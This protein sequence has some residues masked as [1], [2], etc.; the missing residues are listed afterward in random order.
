MAMAWA[1]T[2]AHWGAC[3]G[4]DE[5][6]TSS[7]DKFEYVGSRPIVYVSHDHH[8]NYDTHS[9][10]DARVGDE[11]G[12][13][14]KERVGI[15]KNIGNAAHPFRLMTSPA[16][17]PDCTRSLYSLNPGMECYLNH[18][19]DPTWGT[20]DKFQGWHGTE[21]ATHYREILIAYRLR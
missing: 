15:I 10:C 9:R 2:S 19:S 18:Y 8:A 20:I 12:D 6:R 5:T 16:P 13:E 1:T 17:G 4:G 11:C 14:P 21:G 7:A 3:C